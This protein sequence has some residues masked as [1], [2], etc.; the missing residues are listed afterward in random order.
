MSARPV[1][2]PG[3]LS[4][5]AYVP[6]KSAAP[7]GV[8]VHKLSSNETPLGPSPRAIEAVR[9]RAGQLALYPDGSAGGVARGDRRQARARSGPHRLRRRLRRYP[10]AARPCLRRARRRGR[11]HRRTASSSTASPSWRPAARRW[12]PRRSTTRPDVEAILGQGHAAHPHGLPRQS[13]QPDR[14]L[15]ALRRGQAPACRPARQR[16]ARARRGL[17]RIRAAQ[18]LRVRPR[19]RGDEPRTSS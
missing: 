7:G 3:I 9:A 5:E 16:P 2:R 18:R 19:A 15:P 1:P 6:G 10:V 11:V 13:Q 4:I 8:K 17:R 12:S 14:D